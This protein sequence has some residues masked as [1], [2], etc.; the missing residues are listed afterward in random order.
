MN[1]IG[2]TEAIVCDVL[3]LVAVI[4]LVVII[5]NMAIQVVLDFDGDS[6]IKKIKKL[7][8]KLKGKT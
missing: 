1:I 3:N 5:G 6:F 4:I 7:I 8:A 2:N